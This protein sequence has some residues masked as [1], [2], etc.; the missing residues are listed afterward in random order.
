M[1]GG[2]ARDLVLWWP[3][4]QGKEW[5]R[6]RSRD[7]ASP[8]LTSILLS[9]H[10]P[11]FSFSHLLASCNRLSPRL[12]SAFVFFFFVGLHK[13]QA[14]QSGLRADLF[15]AMECVCMRPLPTSMCR[16]SPG[17]RILCRVWLACCCMPVLPVLN[18]HVP[19]AHKLVII[20]SSFTDT[21]YRHIWVACT[22][23]ELA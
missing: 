15:V 9:Y 11:S 18:N 4:W 17:A 2:P 14:E 3:F 7:S 8:H 12:F 1:V 10:H 23:C 21:V 13:R 22:N 16:W 19:C 5:A 6:F 20:C